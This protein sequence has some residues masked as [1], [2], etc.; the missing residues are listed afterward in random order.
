MATF[1]K[2]AQEIK[3][4]YPEY[5]NVDDAKL[6]KAFIEKYPEYE[7]QVTWAPDYTE[8]ER[9]AD[10]STTPITTRDGKVVPVNTSQLGADR[11]HASDVFSLAKM[12]VDEDKARSK[13]R[14]PM[15]EPEYIDYPVQETPRAKLIREMYN[16]GGMDKEIARKRGDIDLATIFPRTMSGKFTQ[17]VDEAIDDPSLSNVGRVPVEA[18]LTGTGTALDLLSIPGRT[19]RGMYAGATAPDDETV[20]EAMQNTISKTTGDNI[21]S[22]ILIDPLTFATMGSPSGRLIDIGSVG[23]GKGGAKIATILNAPT[24]KSAIGSG[25]GEAALQSAVS[26]YD[27][28]VEGYEYAPSVAMNTILGR[29]GVRGGDVMNKAEK[30]AYG[31]LTPSA[32]Q[33]K[34]NPKLGD[35][36]SIKP[37]LE[38]E[39]L[40]TGKDN[41]GRDILANIKR[42]SSDI[43]ERQ[44]AIRYGEPT[45]TNVFSSTGLHNL[46]NHILGIF[47]DMS[48]DE[49]KAFIQNQPKLAEKLKQYADAWQD[50]EIA[51]KISSASFDS[52]P[53]KE[54]LIASGFEK[55]PNRILDELKAS[56][57]SKNKSNIY[58]FG[59]EERRIRENL[60]SKG[61]DLYNDLKDL[62]NAG[63]V[64]DGNIYKNINSIIDYKRKLSKIADEYGSFD[65]PTSEQNAKAKIYREA[66]DKIDSYIN[67]FTSPEALDPLLTEIS[68]AKHISDEIA[69]D[70]I[71]SLSGKEIADRTYDRLLKIDAEKANLL[72]PES[73]RIADFYATQQEFADI[74]PWR[75]V[76]ASRMGKL[77]TA[78]PSLI[79]AVNAG[80]KQVLKDVIVEQLTGSPTT[81]GLTPRS[82]QKM[83]TAG[84]KSVADGNAPKKTVTM[85]VVENT[86]RNA[87]APSMVYDK[88]ENGNIIYAPRGRITWDELWAD[89]D[90]KK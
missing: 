43:G 6:A 29:Y 73:K 40:A 45:E 71:R 32:S 76:V 15:E 17:S 57:T 7:S 4:K 63:V 21:G 51:L 75:D 20:S 22:S 78:R 27:R 13:G 67:T 55:V 89:V 19:I 53:Y 10:I 85:K 50:E 80:P 60:L 24:W 49:Q 83:Y 38:K 47:I 26:S 11:V 87:L 30:A 90:K 54:Q 25:A 62:A 82:I 56:T 72:A 88:D 34:A 31:V 36:E 74:L 59:T 64:E 66:V 77:N 8:Y 48:V 28:P 33:I 70:G 86:A 65:K 41:A 84:K 37:L 2:F 46:L 5:A 81:T 68:T 79:D 1:T 42:A 61:G 18:V 23:L 35:V 3:K 12:Y 52:S 16:E 44:D 14:T 9:K 69:S 39:I 58:N